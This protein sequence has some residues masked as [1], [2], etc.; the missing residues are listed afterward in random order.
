MSEKDT[1]NTNKSTDSSIPPP[2]DPFPTYQTPYPR[3]SKDDSNPFIQF[4]RFADEQLSS[5][6]QG[7]PQLLGFSA[8]RNPLKR[9]WEDLIRQSH[10]LEEGWRK[11][12]EQEMEEMRQEVEKARTEVW[13]ARGDALTDNMPSVT[14]E[15]AAGQPA[16][17]GKESYDAKTRP[18][19]SD[20]HGLPRTELDAYNGLQLPR[21]ATDIPVFKSSSREAPNNPLSSWFSSFGWDGKQREQEN[22]PDNRGTSKVGSSSEGS[23]LARPTTYTLFG[24]RRMNPFD[25]TDQTIPWLLLSPYSPIYLC[26]PSQSRLFK[27]QIQDSE[28]EPFQI[29]RPRFFERWYTDIDEKL[30]RQIRWADAFEDLISLQQTGK[31]VDRDSPDRDSPTRQVPSSDWIHGLIHRGSLGPTWGLNQEGVVVKRFSDMKPTD[32]R[33]F[34]KSQCRWRTGGGRVHEKGADE[35]PTSKEQS[36]PGLTETSKDIFDDFVDSAAERLGPFP[37][38]GSILSAADSIIS[39]VDQTAKDLEAMSKGAQAESQAD[40]ESLAELPANTSYYSTSSS[41]SYSYENSFTSTREEQITPSESLVS[42]L[43][44]TVTRT[45]PDGSVET[46]R[47]LKRRFAN[48][49]EETDESVEVTTLPGVQGTTDAKTGVNKQIQTLPMTEHRGPLQEDVVSSNSSQDIL[50][51]QHVGSNS[52]QTAKR[53]DKNG[54]SSK[55]GWFWT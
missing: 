21:T 49:T 10:D 53:D 42:T 47:V 32:T 44:T 8:S 24:A 52:E 33:S 1:N 51:Q 11:Q 17:G 55:G 2:L 14:R 30:A 54:R 28:G 12:V 50:V 45:L 48:G 37:L 40:P 4:R 20:E 41:S 35:A 39:A 5:F 7:I 29:S 15:D 16:R 38:F 36:T 31:M 9:D 43:T 22:W 26:N 25:N 34:G 23:Q 27:I 6:F 13:K 18:A 3:S 19:L 46:K